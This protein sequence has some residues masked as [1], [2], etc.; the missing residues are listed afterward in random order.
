MILGYIV[1]D[2]HPLFKTIDIKEIEEYKGIKPILIVGIEYAL[3]YNENLRISENQI[4]KD[5]YFIFSKE[6]SGISQNQLDDY[7]KFLFKH[8]TK[9]YCIVDIS[10]NPQDLI[11][12]SEYCFLYETNTF[13]TLTTNDVIY[14]INKEIYYYF[15]KTSLKKIIN[16]IPKKILSWNS[17]IFF[18]AYLKTNNCYIS[19]E[20]VKALLK[21]YGDINLYMG[22]FCLNWFNELILSK[23]NFKALSLWNRAYHIETYL[24]TLKIKI[25]TK[26][27]NSLVDDSEL[28]QSIE[29]DLNDGYVIQKYNG[30]DKT[31]GRMYVKD[32]SFSLQT[33]AKQYRDLVIAE[34]DCV[35]IEYDYDYFEYYLLSQICNLDLQGDP[36][37]SMSQL[38]WNDEEHRSEAKTINY[39]IL[40]GQSLS[41]TIEQLNINDKQELTI[42][43][44]E[45]LQPLEE[46]KQE[47][48]IE[49]KKFGYITN[50]FGR[51][52]YPEK[53]YA[54]LNNYIQSTAA[55]YFIIKLEKIIDLLPQYE[56]DNKIVLQNHDSVLLNL[57][58]N[59]IETT[60]LIDV[61]NELLESEE[62]DI[63]GKV[64]FKYGYDWKNIE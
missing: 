32:S 35:L 48:I 25:N 33:L 4:D 31:T 13:I 49:Y 36:H 3:Q 60:D 54:L 10:K 19:Q 52:I 12:E 22:V 58:I 41:K 29:D 6:E 9:T 57:N 30:T 24:S 7:I 46:F 17:H 44:E 59:T 56:G 15:N 37:I 63:N 21:N 64:S 50:Y 27:L 23:I 8:Y 16:N 28:F 53:D 40:F 38:I 62:E 43:L 2:I 55:D 39:A 26:K 1:N 14:Y 5:I 11:I 47:L 45:I 18:G 42:K 51:V 61:L 20:S 34:K